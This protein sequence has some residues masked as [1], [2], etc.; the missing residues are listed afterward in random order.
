[1]VKTVMVDK[2]FDVISDL[3]TNDTWSGQIGK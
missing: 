3:A 1:M 2:V